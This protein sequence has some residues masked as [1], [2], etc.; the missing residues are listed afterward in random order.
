MLFK[1][2]YGMAGQESVR[3]RPRTVRLQP[4]PDFH[5][6][7][8]D[9]EA[10]QNGEGSD[11]HPVGER[12]SS[13]QWNTLVVETG[14]EH[15]VRARSRGQSHPATSD[16]A[17]EIPELA[18]DCFY[19]EDRHT[20]GLPNTAATDRESGHFAGTTCDRK[21]WR[22]Y[23]KFYLVGWIRGCGIRFWRCSEK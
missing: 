23:A 10:E 3:K 17:V 22:D 7:Q 16:N 12:R 8:T 4:C 18:F 14:C 11:A 9:G 2:M 21:G 15:C 13:S 6:M 5:D 20:T 1:A 19:M